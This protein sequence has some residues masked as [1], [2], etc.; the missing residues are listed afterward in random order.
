MKTKVVAL[1]TIAV[2]F[3]LLVLVGMVTLAA[4]PMWTGKEVK[5]NTVPVDPRSLFRGNYARLRYEIS[6]VEIPK[7]LT[8]KKIRNGEIIYTLL[9]P[10]ENN[11]YSFKNISLDKPET[12]IFLRGRVSQKRYYESHHRYQVKYGIEAYFAPKDKALALEK[13]LREEGIAVL[14]ISKSGKARLKEIISANIL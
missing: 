10:D 8:K 3:Q 2:I 1:L 5:I 6:E 9:Q 4:S 11:I 12:G 14:M 7:E 13:K